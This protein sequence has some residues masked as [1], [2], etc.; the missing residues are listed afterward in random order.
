MA[1]VSVRLILHRLRIWQIGI[2]TLRTLVRNIVFGGMRYYARPTSKI[3]TYVNSTEREEPLIRV[4]LMLR[5]MGRYGAC[6]EF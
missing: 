1:F 2:G 6:I 3:T 4:C 5:V